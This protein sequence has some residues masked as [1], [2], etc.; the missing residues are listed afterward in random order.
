[1]A[2]NGLGNLVQVLETGTN[3]IRIDEGVRQRAL[4]PV[5]RMLDFA[6]G[7]SVTVAGNA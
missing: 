5:Q 4:V 7:R 2:M 1:M 6:T 3:E